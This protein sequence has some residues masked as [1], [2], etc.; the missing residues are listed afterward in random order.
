M[1]DFQASD[2]VEICESESG[3][4]EGPESGYGSG[5]APNSERGL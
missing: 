1:Q 4:R 2:K 3:V 5:K